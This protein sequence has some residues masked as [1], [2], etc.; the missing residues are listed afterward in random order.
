M[1]TLIDIVKN[2]FLILQK[3]ILGIQF[4]VSLLGVEIPINLEKFQPPS[5]KKKKKKK[6][7]ESVSE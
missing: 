6:K 4:V 3:F 7:R 1:T 2:T 5:P